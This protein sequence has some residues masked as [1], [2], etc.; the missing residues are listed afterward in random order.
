[1]KI[2]TAKTPATSTH[3][4]VHRMTARELV[5]AI[6]TC[7]A[8]QL[9]GKHTTPPSTEHVVIQRLAMIALAAFAE[10]DRRADEREW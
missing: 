8:C 10:I 6:P 4:S 3:A 7:P 1:M 9:G 2:V 5:R